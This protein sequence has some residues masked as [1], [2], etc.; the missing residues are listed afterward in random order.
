MA[1]VLQQAI[2]HI[3]IIAGQITSGTPSKASK[4]DEEKN[5][6]SLHTAVVRISAII[7]R[8]SMIFNSKTSYY[9]GHI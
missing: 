2:S 9:A 8:K 7:Q 6:P 1:Y 3:N 5:E 4:S